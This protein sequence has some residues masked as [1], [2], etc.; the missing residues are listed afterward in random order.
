MRNND[1]GCERT[2]LG[3]LVS[4][5]PRGTPW[6][7]TH[8]F[9]VV[10]H[11]G[12]NPDE[13]H[14]WGIS[15][16]YN[17]QACHSRGSSGRH[18]A[19]NNPNTVGEPRERELCELSGDKLTPGLSPGPGVLYLWNGQNLMSRLRKRVPRP[20]GSKGSRISTDIAERSGDTD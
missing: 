15:V 10:E 19:M 12:L 3:D 5:L 11:G 7:G 17:S 1:K 20:Q 8:R 16:L 4:I 6:I 2:T 9:L 18:T 14:H 13:V